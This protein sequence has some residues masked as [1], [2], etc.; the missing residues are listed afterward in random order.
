V[1]FFFTQTK[2]IILKQHKYIKAL[3]EKANYKKIP[4]SQ[5]T[6]GE[7]IAS[8][9]QQWRHGRSGAVVRKSLAMRRLVVSEDAVEEEHHRRPKDDVNAGVGE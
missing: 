3:V 8:E 1:R 7:Q 4:R 6:A 9:L 5:N 2:Y